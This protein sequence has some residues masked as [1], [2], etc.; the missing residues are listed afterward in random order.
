MRGRGS[1]VGDGEVAPVGIGGVLELQSH[2]H[3]APELSENT[4]TVMG[5]KDLS[6]HRLSPEHAPDRW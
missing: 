5:R 2:E 1:S 6:N 3:V 4:F